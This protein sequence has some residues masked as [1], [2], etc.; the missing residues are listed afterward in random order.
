MTSQVGQ[1]ASVQWALKPSISSIDS[2]MKPHSCLTRR[3]SNMNWASSWPTICLSTLVVSLGHK[4][5]EIFHFIAIKTRQISIH[6]LLTLVFSVTIS[7]YLAHIICLGTRNLKKKKKKAFL[8]FSCKH[9][10][11]RSWILN[12]KFK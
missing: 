4:N 2:V 3:I 1:K 10:Y 5:I 11:K 7:L 6:S 12:I 8:L 9:Y